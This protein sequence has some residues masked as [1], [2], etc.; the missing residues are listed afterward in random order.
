MNWGSLIWTALSH[1]P[2]LVRLAPKFVEIVKAAVTLKNAFEEMS[3]VKV[4][5][6]AGRALAG[7]KDAIPKPQEIKPGSIEEQTWFDRNTGPAN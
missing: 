2:T 1:L 7:A 3:G 6:I 4:S 5:D